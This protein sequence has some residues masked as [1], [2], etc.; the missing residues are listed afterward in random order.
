MRTITPALALV[1]LLVGSAPARAA[2][3]ADEVKQA[4][5]SFQEGQKLFDAGDHAAALEHFRAALEVTAS[6]N[7]RL[8]VARC[9]REIGR[10]PEA[11]EEM[12]R[13]LTE[14]RA[15]AESEPKYAGTRDASAAEL[16]VLESR[17]G[18]VLVALADPPEGAEVTLGGEI[19]QGDRLGAPIAVAPGAVHIVARA[20]GR[21]E[22]VR[23]VDV[24]AGALVSVALSL[25]GESAT[26]PAATASAARE[27]A[28]P[29]AP[30][31]GG[32]A[33]TLGWILL[34]V[35]GA[36]FV[37]FGVAGSMANAQYDSI[38]EDCGGSR[39]SDPR[40]AADIDR[41]QRLDSIANVGLIVGGAGVLGGAGLLLFGSSSS[42]SH[43]GSARLQLRSTGSGF[44]LRGAF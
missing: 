10:L 30:S 41:G 6:P 29:P 42:E 34:G 3:G 7:A 19:V 8:Y 38:N 9:L 26:E 44:T 39:C 12:R 43:Q 14:S 11:Y 2:P 20:P 15:R 16:A 31:D 27:P 28:P 4:Q 17:V 13:T 24:A 35:G 5:A 1:L 33:R 37:T 25:R 23:D 21:T 32:T 40:F 22:V 18:R 36:G